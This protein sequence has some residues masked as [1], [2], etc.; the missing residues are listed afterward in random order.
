MSTAIL[1]RFD[2][3]QAN[4]IIAYLEV[5]NNKLDEEGKRLRV[6]QSVMMR[7]FLSQLRSTYNFLIQ[8]FMKDSVLGHYTREIGI[9]C[10]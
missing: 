3:L 7:K 9:L 10:I 2:F 6:E 1:I 4:E 8:K 5:D